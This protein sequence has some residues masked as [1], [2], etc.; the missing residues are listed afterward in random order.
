VGLRAWW[1]ERSPWAKAAARE[2]RREALLASISLAEADRAVATLAGQEPLVPILGGEPDAYADAF[3]RRYHGWGSAAVRVVNEP[4][5]RG[6]RVLAYVSDDAFE[7]AAEVRPGSFSVEGWNTTAAPSIAHL[8]LG[9]MLEHEE[10]E[11]LVSGS[12]A[13]LRARAR[14]DRLL[15]SQ[16]AGRP[17]VNDGRSRVAGALASTVLVAA[18]AGL[19]VLQALVLGDAPWG[20]W[21]C[22]SSVGLAISLAGLLGLR[23]VV[24][25]R[26][27]R[28]LA[29]D[30]DGFREGHRSE[31]RRVGKECRRLCRSRWSPYH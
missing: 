8:V 31:E 3:A 23:S 14:V 6:R 27:A 4:W 5:F 17:F 22:W 18:G 12:D 26:R 15:A 2:A 29:M 30:V 19:L 24:R 11:A 16:L 13:W 20:E 28:S 10:L 7:L 9:A 25:H 21:L 1:N